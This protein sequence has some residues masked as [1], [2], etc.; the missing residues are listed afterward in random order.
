[1][2]KLMKP[3]AFIF[4]LDGVITDTAH[5]HFLAW[6]DLAHSL[7]IAF[8][9]VFNEKLKGVGRMESLE[10]ILEKGGKAQQFS[11]AEKEAMATHKNELYK[12]LIV[13][14]TPDEVLPNIKPLLATLRAEGIKIGLASASKNAFTVLACLEMQAS[15]DYVAD[16]AKIP[17]S[18][19]APDVFLDV[20]QAFQL[21]VKDCIGVED[22]AAGVESI[23]RA[24]M[25]A[26]GIGDPAHLP[27]ADILFASTSLLDLH[28]IYTAYTQWLKHP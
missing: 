25:M 28:K 5:Y 21:P 6:R 15:F 8:D 10:L 16:A 24:G 26:V 1:M 11:A 17:N 22:A 7:G 3:K 2:D 12:A 13:K 23:H 14:M 9:E 4:D 19:P 18:K 27:K 20:A